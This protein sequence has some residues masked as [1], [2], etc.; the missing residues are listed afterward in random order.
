MHQQ[1]FVTRKIDGDRVLGQYIL[2]GSFEVDG[3]GDTSAVY[4]RAAFQ[5]KWIL[6]PRTSEWYWRIKQSAEG[7]GYDTVELDDFR[8]PP[9]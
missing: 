6:P 7:A 9:G 2:D 1:Y 8:Y 4:Q 5:P 3:K